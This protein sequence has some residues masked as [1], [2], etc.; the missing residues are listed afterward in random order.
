MAGVEFSQFTNGGDIVAGDIV[1]GLRGG[2]NTKFNF[3]SVITVSGTL[4]Q[5]V[6][7]GTNNAVISIANNPILPGVAGVTV[8]AGSTAQRSGGDGT[9]RFNTTTGFTEFT[10]DGSTWNNIT[11]TVGTVTDVTA[12]S[13]L[14]SSG[15][16]TPNISL[17]GIVSGANGGTGIA[18]T[19]KTITI[20]GNFAMSGGFTFVGTITGNTTV[21]F[22]TSGTLATTGG[23]S[24]PSLV[25]GDTLY[26]SATNVLSALA[27]DTGST[28]YL[29]NTGTSNN[30][31]WAQIAL[32]TGVT[33]ILPGTNG[34]TGVNNGASLITVGANFTMSGAFTFVGTLTG[35]TTVT[36]PTSGTLA[37]TGGASIPSVAQGDLLYGSAA[38][39]LSALNKD[40]NATR[41]L[42]NTGA[43]NNP[44]WAQVSLTTGVTGILPGTNGGT[45]VNNGG[46]LITIGGN[47]T[48]SGGF[49]FTGTIT[50]NTSVTFPTS[51][52]LATTGGAS[53]PSIAQ[54][55]LL[56]GSA[57]N[58]LSA[59]NKDTNA[60]R[61]L[62]N[63]G[64][65]NNPAW[66]QIAL[67]TGV[68]GTLPSANGGTGVNNGSSTFTIGG[69]FALSGAFTF[70]GTVT[71]N[72]TVT[73][74]TSGT[75]A[76]TG[77]ASIPSLVQ[78]DL[79]YASATNVLSALAKDTNA[80]RYLS[81]TGTTNNPA[82]AQINL[83]NGVT[84]LLTGTNGG[85]GVNNGASTITIGGNFAMSGAFTFTG[86]V[87]G[88][89]AVTFPT[90][91]TLATTGGAN[92]PTI[93]QGDLLYGSATNVLSA[94]TKDAN[95]TRYLSNTGSSNNPAW[96]QVNLTNGVTGT[97]PGTNG[98]TGITTIANYP[99]QGRITL[100]S[101][102]PV[103]TSDVTAAT[104]VYYTPYKGNFI[105][106]YTS[107]VWKMYTFSEL[108]IAVPATTAT[109]YDLYVYDSG[110]NATLEAVAWTND[111][112]RATA[113]VFQNGVYCKTGALDR[114]YVGSFRTTGSS[115]Q[116][117]DSN[118]KRFVWNYYNRVIKSMQNAI[119]TTD[120]WTYT[121][122]AFRQANANAANQLDFIIGVS[123]D[124]VEAVVVAL[125]SNSGVSAQIAT[126]IGLDVTNAT[127]CFIKG[128]NN[129]PVLSALFYNASFYK[130]YPGV[131]RHFLAWLEYSTASGTTTWYGDAGIPTLAQSGISGTGNF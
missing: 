72:T 84:G 126:G 129:L 33:G 105:A 61:Y 63:T 94:L 28:R 22:P 52:T 30:P 7:T 108:S 118:Q 14:A 121:T 9:I 104:T 91:G 109:M 97:L 42:S 19:G 102:S 117:E 125:A 127:S 47:V 67:S 51:G 92:I 119:E 43:S 35:A 16:T 27:K 116:T 64:S 34:G 90:S 110:G 113:L 70:T 46:S 58:V 111:T 130:D 83:A 6:V 37:T 18:N 68:T 32:T 80:T 76:T 98:G 124:V 81:N 103:T 48:F 50:G 17:T 8:P 40:T 95:A 78:G 100:T 75:L 2:V 3:N 23:A 36:F 106:L 10:N 38:N 114:R 79:L 39:V 107:S 13:P 66:A 101:G 59:L 60:T 5:I 11:S 112:T 31:A 49:T 88:N 44:A 85:T 89:T 131:G 21:T 15:G 1:V 86:T 56:Y 96:S 12:S 73:F 87:T 4:N 71:G 65:S 53:I 20:G 54:G 74:P 41:Y 77:G 123:E 82:W 26:A 57:T 69:N 29:S 24:I 45:G 93:A 128:Y 115:G 25:Q 120:S 122:A 62:S 99:A 55:D